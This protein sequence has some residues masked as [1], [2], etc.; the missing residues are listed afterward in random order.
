[1]VGGLGFVVELN[2]FPVT[3]WLDGYAPLPTLLNPWTGRFSLRPGFIGLS[4]DG[5]SF[6]AGA[7]ATESGA[8]GTGRDGQ[9]TSSGGAGR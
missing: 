2:V 5:S 4:G 9:V 3:K 7:T 6:L 1:V 8:G